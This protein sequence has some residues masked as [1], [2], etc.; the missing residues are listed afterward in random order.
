MIPKHFVA[1]NGKVRTEY[2]E[3]VFRD[4]PEATSAQHVWAIVVQ[5]HLPFVV[6]IDGNALDVMSPDAAGMPFPVSGGWSFVAA[7]PLLHLFFEAEEDAVLARLH[8]S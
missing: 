1:P 3:Q 2:W 8:F 4:D 5:H 6:T 7:W